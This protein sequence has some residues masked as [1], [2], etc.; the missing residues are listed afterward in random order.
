MKQLL[1]IFA[2]LLVTALFVFLSL[3]QMR[4]DGFWLLLICYWTVVIAFWLRGSR[5]VALPLVGGVALLACHV[6]GYK[7]FGSPTVT[8]SRPLLKHPYTLASIAAPNILI[9]T[10]GSRHI[11]RGISFYPEIATM[12]AEEQIATIDPRREPLR[13]EASDES[14]SGY[15]GEGRILYWC[16][17]TWFPRPLPR[18]LPSHEIEDVAKILRLVTL[19]A[20][21]SE[22]AK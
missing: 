16:G 17:N 9:A 3:V 13:F 19:Q 1:V 22:N 15:V 8:D 21:Q 11:V 12:S 4:G 5:L 10:D 18:S 2:H 20:P 14:P 6:A 7:L